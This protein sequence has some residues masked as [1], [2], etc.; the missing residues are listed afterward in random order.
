M[1]TGAPTIGATGSPLMSPTGVLTMGEAGAAPSGPGAV[2][3]IAIQYA[4]Q[5]WNPWDDNEG[6]IQR[7]RM[8]WNPDVV[9]WNDLWT[10]WMSMG[11][12]ASYTWY[13]AH[14]PWME[15]D[16]GWRL[17]HLPLGPALPLAPRETPPAQ[18]DMRFPLLNAQMDN[19]EFATVVRGQ[20]GAWSLPRWGHY[21]PYTSMPFEL[22]MDS[23]NDRVRFIPTAREWFAEYSRG[24]VSEPPAFVNYNASRWIK[25]MSHRLRALIDFY[26]GG[27]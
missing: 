24:G 11:P 25:A 9:E 2:V 6:N 19:A 22:L 5:Y 1:S 8:F 17:V 4:S 21:P 13:V 26:G 23:S 27:P 15:F 12:P 14:V 16:Y 3:I 20:W 18:F 10:E 7:I